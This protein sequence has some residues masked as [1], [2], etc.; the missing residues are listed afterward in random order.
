MTTSVTVK[1]TEL[2]PEKLAGY[3]LRAPMLSAQMRHETP[4]GTF[5]DYIASHVKDSDP[6]ELQFVVDLLTKSTEEICDRWFGGELNACKAL[7]ASREEW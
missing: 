3:V 2:D 7:M 6:L 4:T 1:M 5:R